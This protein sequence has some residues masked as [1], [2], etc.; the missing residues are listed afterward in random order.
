MTLKYFADKSEA[1]PI[2]RIVGI[3]VSLPVLIIMALT[4]FSVF[5]LHILKMFAE[6]YDENEAGEGPPI[7]TATPIHAVELARSL[8]ST[9]TNSGLDESKI[10]ACTETFQLPNEGDET[11]ENGDRKTCSICLENYG[12]A[13]ELR[14]IIKCGHCFHASCIQQWLGKNSTCPVCRTS[15]CHVDL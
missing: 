13:D 1:K 2:A 12:S 15:L 11:I 8:S 3:A 6:R 5:C 4:C 14:L 10:I 7:P 9:I